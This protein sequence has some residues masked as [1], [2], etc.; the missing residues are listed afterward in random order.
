MLSFLLMTFLELVWGKERSIILCKVRNATLLKWAERVPNQS[1]L[2]NISISYKYGLPH[3]V[4]VTYFYVLVIL[5][6]VRMTWTPGSWSCG[7]PKWQ[8]EESAMM[9]GRLNLVNNNCL[10]VSQILHTV[11]EYGYS[12]ILCSSRN[13]KL[14]RRDR[15]R[16][17]LH[18]ADY[19]S[20][21]PACYVTTDRGKK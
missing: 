3:K 19:D 20:S 18:T 6:P 21:L 7:L 15:A 17:T 8:N 14:L 4:I 10:L 9:A 2:V 5:R 16:L 12:L 11:N 13:R 1:F